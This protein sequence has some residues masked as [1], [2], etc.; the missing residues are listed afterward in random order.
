MFHECEICIFI[1]TGKL[2]HYN[3]NIKLGELVFS[4]VVWKV[5]LSAWLS[6]REV[7]FFHLY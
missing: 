4:S 5:L 6:V 7:I 1:T 2:A 3:C